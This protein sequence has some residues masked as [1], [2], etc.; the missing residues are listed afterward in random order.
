MSQHQSCSLHGKDVFNEHVLTLTFPDCQV[1]CGGKH[2]SY[3]GG[4]IGMKVTSPFN[5]AALTDLHSW[6]SELSFVVDCR[7]VRSWIINIIISSINM[8]NLRIQTQAFSSL[9]TKTCFS[10][11]LLF[12]SLLELC[13]DFQKDRCS[14]L[15][16]GAWIKM[17][18]HQL[19]QHNSSDFN[20]NWQMRT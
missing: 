11:L 9:S 7:K 14:K 8:L 5:T 12:P 16:R 2:K 6:F 3:I 13:R 10:F 17:L 18:E 19:L 15:K 1:L 20:F 4:K